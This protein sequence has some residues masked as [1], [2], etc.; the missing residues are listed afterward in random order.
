MDRILTPLSFRCD[1]RVGTTANPDYAIVR[2]SYQIIHPN[3]F[4]VGTH[5]PRIRMAGKHQEG[6]HMTLTVVLVVLGLVLAESMLVR[7][8]NDTKGR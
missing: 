6:T 1:D 7:W 4:T 2:G 8:L 5:I 3:V